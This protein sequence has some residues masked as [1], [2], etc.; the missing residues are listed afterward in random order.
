MEEHKVP[1]P[2]TEHEPTLNQH[3]I[4][5]KELLSISLNYRNDAN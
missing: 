5:E 4:T 1:T 2:P 3:Q